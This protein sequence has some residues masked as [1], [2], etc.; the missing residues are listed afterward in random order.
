MK[1]YPRKRKKKNN[2]RKCFMGIGLFFFIYLATTLFQQNQTLKDLQE[3]KNSQES[4]IARIQT[5]IEGLNEEIA[6]KDS[7][8]FVEKIAREKL[9]MVKPREYVY[10]DEA[11]PQHST[12]DDVNTIEVD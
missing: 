1:T 7:L 6:Q 11:N 10:I 5:E 3:R 12:V 8:E 9:G 2:F 4:E